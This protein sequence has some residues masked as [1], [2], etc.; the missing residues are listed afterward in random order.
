MNETTTIRF[1]NLD[2]VYMNGE[3]VLDGVMTDIAE[4]NE[5]TLEDLEREGVEV[6]AVLVVT[7]AP[8]SQETSS[9]TAMV[10][11]IDMDPATR[12]Y[13]GMVAEPTEIDETDDDDA[14]EGILDEEPL[15]DAGSDDRTS[16]GDG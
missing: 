7:S 9:A 11:P 8:D 2:Y 16:H 1:T 14:E 5:T 13:V 12:D 3:S 15:E 6:T 4:A 10:A